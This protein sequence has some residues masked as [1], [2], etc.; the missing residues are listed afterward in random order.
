MQKFQLGVWIAAS[1]LGSFQAQAT[2]YLVAKDPGSKLVGMAV[3]TSGP[4]YSKNTI[5][6]GKSK[7]GLVGWGGN[8]TAF[9][10]KIDQL[11]F[12]LMEKNKT[13]KEISESVM[14]THGNG[15]YRFAFASVD[16]EIGTVLPPGGCKTPEC[17]QEIDPQHQFFVIGGGLEKGVLKNSL[18]RYAKIHSQKKQHLACKLLEGLK[19]IVETGGEIHDFNAAQIAI[20]GTTLAEPLWFS[21]LFS[22]PKKNEN[23]ILVGLA[24]QIKAQGIQCLGFRR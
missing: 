7:V 16:G 8:S 14:S 20:D 12:E 22:D 17:G 1:I 21:F 3:I 19:A 2:I 11:T 6:R 23:D 9:S 13:S 10:S 4:V 18:A 15:Y 5:M 24:K